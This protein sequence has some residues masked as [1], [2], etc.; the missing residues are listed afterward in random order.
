MSFSAGVQN[1]YVFIPI[2][3]SEHLTLSCGKLSL[4]GT[5]FEKD[6]SSQ[7]CITVTRRLMQYLQANDRCLFSAL[8]KSCDRTQGTF[9]EGGTYSDHLVLHVSF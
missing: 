3:L 7:C 5:L 8:V 9:K 4:R 1:I 6:R 2:F